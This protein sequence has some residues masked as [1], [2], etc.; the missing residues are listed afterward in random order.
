LETWF[1]VLH[2]LR[3]RSDYLCGSVLQGRV[4]FPIGG[5][6]RELCSTG[7][8]RLNSGTDSIVWMEEEYVVMI[9][10]AC[11]QEIRCCILFILP[12]N[13]SAGFFFTG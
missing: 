1:L 6:V 2:L 13:F 3:I 11:A 5:I 12:R 10:R 7:L 8:N 4:K 9:P